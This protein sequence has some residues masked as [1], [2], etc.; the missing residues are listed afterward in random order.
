MS[1]KRRPKKTTPAMNYEQEALRT[2]SRDMFAIRE[3]LEPNVIR[4]LHAGVGLATEAGEFVD[5]VKKH[6]FYGKPLD[7]TNLREEVGDVLWYLAVACDALGTSFEA[8]MERNIS[9]LRS[10]YPEAFDSARACTR[11]LAA[12]RAVLEG[13][14]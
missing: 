3:R 12:E 14:R 4:L 2:E 9:K 7:L 1:T 8:E 13:G 10:R 5:V 11:N 6:I